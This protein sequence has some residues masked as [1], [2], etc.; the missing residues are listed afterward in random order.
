M[1]I[2]LV[3]KRAWVAGI[4]QLVRRRDSECELFYD[5]IVHVEAS[6]YVH[7]TDFLISTINIYARPNLCT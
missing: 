7:S 3:D 2:P 1:V 4:Q 5:D 6:A